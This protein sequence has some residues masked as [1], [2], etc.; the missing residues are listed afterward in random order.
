MIVVMVGQETISRQQPPIDN[1][2]DALVHCEPPQSTWFH[3]SLV[4]TCG[5]V[6]SSPSPS[7]FYPLSEG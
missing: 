2:L 7:Q 6:I 5:S 4:M 1:L 3:Y